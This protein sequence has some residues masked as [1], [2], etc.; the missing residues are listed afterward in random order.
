MSIETTL[1]KQSHHTVLKPCPRS[2]LESSVHFSDT[3]LLQRVSYFIL[4]HC[5]KTAVSEHQHVQHQ[6]A[7]DISGQYLRVL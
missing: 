5:W 2:L 7:P 4:L 6:I 1:G 3:K